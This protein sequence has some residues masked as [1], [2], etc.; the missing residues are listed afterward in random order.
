MVQVWKHR[1]RASLPS[2]CQSRR[3]MFP[4]AEHAILKH[5]ANSQRKLID[6]ARELTDAMLNSRSAKSQNKYDARKFF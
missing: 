1:A 5:Q 4:Q 6:E 3:V 2:G